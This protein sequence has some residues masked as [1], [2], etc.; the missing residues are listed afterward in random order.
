MNLEN[1]YTYLKLKGLSVE[2]IKE[3]GH[4][5]IEKECPAYNSGSQQYWIQKFRNKNVL[6]VVESHSYKI[7][8]IFDSKIKKTHFSLLVND[9]S[10]WNNYFPCS[11]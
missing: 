9:K 8:I 3:C 11:I 7:W 2:A 10:F 5:Y 6:V 4:N 1:V